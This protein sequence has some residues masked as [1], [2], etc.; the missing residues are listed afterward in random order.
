MEART[1]IVTGAAGGL[2]AAVAQLLAANGHNLMLVDNRAEA[3]A[4]V[5][6]ELSA[7][8]AR[9]EQ[10]AVDLSLASECERVVAES[11][12]R[13]GKVDILVNAAAILA[14]QALAEVT[15]ESFDHIFHVNARAPFFLMQAAMADMARRKWGRIV[16]CISIGVYQGGNT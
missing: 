5:G 2:G 10:L 6:G 4:A 15:A 11:V 8:G 9:V 1:A 16:N 14:R 12:N 13:L 3:L 7:T